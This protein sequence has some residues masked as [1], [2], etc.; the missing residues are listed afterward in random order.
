MSVQKMTWVLQGQVSEFRY[1]SLHE[2]VVAIG[3]LRRASM[4]V[5][6]TV[7]C[8]RKT[9]SKLPYMLKS[10]LQLLSILQL[11]QKNAIPAVRKP[12]KE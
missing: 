5:P 4:L 6:I 2:G 1:M 12:P 8:K 11:K 7:N 10:V 3:F 9:Q